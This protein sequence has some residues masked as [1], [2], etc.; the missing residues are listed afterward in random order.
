MLECWSAAILIVL[1]VQYPAMGL[2]KPLDFTSVRFYGR[3]SYSFYLLHP[4]GILFAFRIFDPMALNAH[5]VPL[6]I[7]IIFITLV[8]ITLTTPIAYLMWRFI[9]TP[10][11]RYGRRFGKLPA[12]LAAG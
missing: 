6:S 9:E 2:F 10:C 4:L 8:S 5:G 3:I 7:T 11:I 12:V 1:I